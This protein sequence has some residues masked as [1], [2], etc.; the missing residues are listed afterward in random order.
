MRG[1]RHSIW[2]YCVM[3][4]NADAIFQKLD[5]EVTNIHYRWIMYRHVYAAGAEQTELLNR[6]G[7]NF[8]YCTQFLMLDYIALAFSKIT[9]PNNQ[10]RNENLSLKQF[11]V[12]YSELGEKDLVQNLKGKFEDL[13]GACSKFRDL[14]NKRI[15]HA[16]LQHALNLVEEPLPGISRAYVENALKLLREYMNIINKHRTNSTTLYEET[17]ENLAGSAKKLITA[18][19]IADANA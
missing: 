13:K 6:H 11:H 14:R 17:I 3:E 16:D 12:V 8:F 15:A 5:Y 4:K 10:G 7:A 9:D 19:Q 1:V 18:L 2:R